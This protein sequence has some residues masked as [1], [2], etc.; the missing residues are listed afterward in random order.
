MAD[1]SADALTLFLRRAVR[2]RFDWQAASCL[3]LAADW[4]RTCGYPDPT[5]PWRGRWTDE[6]SA[7]ALLAA[8]GG[9]T[10][11]MQD[12]AKRI[13]LKPTHGVRRGDVGAIDITTPDGVETAA[14]L[15]TGARWVVRAPR[16]LWGGTAPVQ[17]AWRVEV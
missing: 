10:A 15:W 2:Q 12:A 6:A 11:L 7:R 17:A 14:G 5:D 16:G 8:A 4:L 9:L 1:A 13:D 3:G